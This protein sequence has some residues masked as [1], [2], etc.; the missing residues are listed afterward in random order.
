MVKIQEL[1]NK[2]FYKTVEETFDKLTFVEDTHS[3]F[4]KDKKLSAS[5]SKRVSKFVKF[6]DFKRIASD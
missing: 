6:V 1:I 3:Y 5:V 4:I 2:G